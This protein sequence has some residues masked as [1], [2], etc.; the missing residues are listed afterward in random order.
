[1][2]AGKPAAFSLDPERVHTYTMALARF[3][4]VISTPSPRSGDP[5]S[6]PSRL[7]VLF[8][9]CLIA[10]G[11]HVERSWFE[12]KLPA[13]WLHARH[14]DDAVA[15]LRFALA[16]SS[17]VFSTILL[18]WGFRAMRFVINS[19]V[20]FIRII[21]PETHTDL[22]PPGVSMPTLYR[23]LTTASHEADQ[24]RRA[25]ALLRLEELEGPGLV[26]KRFSGSVS[27]AECE[28]GG[29]FI[30][31]GNTVYLNG[32]SFEL[33]STHYAFVRALVEARGNIVSVRDALKRYNIN[34]EVTNST[35][36][37]NQLPKLLRDRIESADSKG[38]RVKN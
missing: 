20:Q 17:E 9:Q 15:H 6:K 5:S 23:P 21:N 13:N 14:H 24:L 19:R 31:P 7:E 22:A 29:I 34:Q 33:D 8:E 30:F 37:V 3:V 11:E 36:F 27:I 2:S 25:I 16:W 4:E 1:M 18:R 28:F 35:H 38:Y 26:V 12:I 10:A 32:R